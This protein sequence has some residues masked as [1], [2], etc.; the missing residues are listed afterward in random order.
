MPNPRSSARPPTL[1]E[2]AEKIGYSKSAVSLAMRD[3]PRMAAET[4]RSIQAEAMKLGYRKNAVLAHLMA[5]LRNS[6]VGAT[7][8]TLAVVNCAPD[9]SIYDWHTF[10]DFR[11]G[12]RRR[13]GQLGYATQ[14]FRLF[15]KGMRPARL[16]QIFHARNLAGM[17]LIGAQ[18]L[19]VL[20]DI[21]EDLWR[22]H[23]V[24]TAGL[25]RT[26]PPLA[27]AACDH[28]QTA[29]RAVRVGLE[30][31]HARPALVMDDALDELTDHR[32]SGGFFSATS[33]L[34]ASRRLPVFRSDGRSGKLFAEWY[35]RH[36]PD[37]IVTLHTEVLTW[38]GELG[39][40]V[41]GETALA[42]LDWYPDMRDWA[43]MKQD[44]LTVGACVVDLVVTQI[45]SNEKGAQG[46]PMV[47][48]VESTWVEGPTVRGAQAAGATR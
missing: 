19:E 28:F 20:H 13:A 42:H 16:R 15:E 18:N 7:Q 45:H 24:S 1:R 44:N 3:D 39:V 27:C 48:L 6:R 25:V 40:A 37:F 4:R 47:T 14:E 46:K 33:G 31:G 17:V 41:P 32:F 5:E 38:L 26:D 2:L 30:R 8:A 9:A 23:P 36:R 34:P 29:Y 22:H 10:R 21:Y 11:E 43:G 35:R 12:A